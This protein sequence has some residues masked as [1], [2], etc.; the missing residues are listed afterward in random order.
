MSG[1]HVSG[2]GKAF[3]KTKKSF[4]GKNPPD[5]HCMIE[6]QVKNILVIKIAW[7]LGM[8]MVFKKLHKNNQINTTKR[9]KIL[10]WS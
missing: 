6:D 3:F 4:A 1:T 5:S 7:Q 2:G 8:R 10:K 9:G